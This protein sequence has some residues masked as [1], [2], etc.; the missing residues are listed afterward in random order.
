ML[1]FVLR[2]AGARHFTLSLLQEAKEELHNTH[3]VL[4]AQGFFEIA[5]GLFNRLG[6]LLRSLSLGIH[7]MRGE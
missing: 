1:S 7:M 3:D 5:V 2:C 6:S 4:I